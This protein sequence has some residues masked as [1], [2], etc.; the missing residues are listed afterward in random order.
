MSEPKV[1][2]AVADELNTSVDLKDPKKGLKNNLK[3]KGSIGLLG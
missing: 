2:P 1:E 3:I